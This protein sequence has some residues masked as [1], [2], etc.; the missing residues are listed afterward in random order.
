MADLRERIA[1]AESG[2]NIIVAKN[3]GF[4]FGV[5]R[6]A[7]SIEERL[8]QAAPGERLF[9][10]GKLIHNDT[11]NS[12]LAE[13]GVGVL[14][15]SE[16]AEVAASASAESSVTLFIRA[17]G[18]TRQTEEQLGRLAAENKH[19]GYIDCTCPYVRKVRAAA[20]E[21][22]GEGKCFIL[23]GNPQ[24]PE[25]V[26]ILSCVE[27]EK[28]V[29]SSADEL[30]A[31]VESGMLG[32]MHKKTA[33]MA[34]Q[35]TFD[36]SE[37][38]KSREIL[39]KLCTNTIIFD[40]I[41]GVTEKRQSE[42][43]SLSEQCDIMIVIGGRE[44]A[45]T[46]GLYDICKKNCPLTYLVADGRELRSILP[47]IK[48][49]IP[50]V[51]TGIVAGAS[52]PAGIIQEVLEIMSENT[53]TRA[54]TFEEMLEKSLKTLNTG[55]VVTGTVTSVTDAELQLDIGAKV[56]G[57]IAADQATD[58]PSAKL[59]EMFQVGDKIDAYVLKVND[60][61]G[62]ATLSKRR[63]DSDRNWQELVK[64]Y[65]DNEVL[66]GRVTGVNKGG[67]EVTINSNRIFVPASQTGVPKDKDMSEL[68]GEAVRIRIIEIK[69]QRKR[70]I[71][72]IRLVL[73]DERRAREAA[74]WDSL[75]VGM[76][77]TGRVKN[78]TSYGAF[79]DLGVV[80]GMVHTTELSWKHIKSPAEVVSIGDEIEVY[81]KSFDRE[82]GRI[83]LSYKTEETEP[84]RVFK[85]RFA[86]GD[87]IKAR[88]VSLMPFG[89]F[90]E[91]ID[92][93]DGLIHISQL[94]I[95][96]VSR[97]EDVLSIGDMVDVKIV[98]IDEEKRN[99]SLS[100]RALLEEEARGE[101][102]ARNEKDSSEADLTEE[103]EEA[104]VAPENTDTPAE[105][106]EVAPAD[107]SE[108]TA[109]EAPVDTPEAD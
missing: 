16:I 94:A 67:V 64:A 59:T 56:T 25:V 104:P 99:V 20:S 10:L 33:V 71:G 13:R 77:F 39:K 68:L 101:L 105:A 42:A 95:T 102:A 21:H 69:P 45:N 61:D 66:E 50:R 40:T 34:V 109:P 89:A 51:K 30:E 4:C 79:V 62:V 96:R 91:I 29:F 3:A 92:G 108:S 7:E 74:F 27:G 88:V 78:M 70:A 54:Q 23:M 38:R 84:W 32:D 9:T 97:P 107:L 83:S 55:E 98:G 81:V 76:K 57:V 37:W 28:Y 19:F 31:A 53:Q 47:E 36:L 93:V 58:D 2:S 86:V 22:S 8:V 106:P 14:D 75:E 100:I 6:A 18:V 82:R 80:D 103:P 72:S 52:T 87:V 12:Y 5:R 63:V 24:H 35:T 85:N 65:E 41:C 43:K 15:E 48:S 44:S 17:H 73:R 1:M 11:Y 26:G 90:A 60:T 46:A 49:K